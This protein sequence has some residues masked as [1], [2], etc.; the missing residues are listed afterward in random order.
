M[1]TERLHNLLQI[2]NN[3][4]SNLSIIS[5]AQ[6]FVNTFTKNIQQPTP[7]Q[8][9]TFNTAKEELKNALSECDSN[10]FVPSQHKMLQKINGDKCLGVGLLTE[11]EIIMNNNILTPGDAVKKVS[12]HFTKVN[13]FSAAIQSA[14]KS[15]ETLEIGFEYTKENEYE[16]GFL[17]PCK[18]FNND[19]EGLQKEVNLINRHMK[20]ICELVG[21]EITS[22]QIRS[23]ST[24]SLEVFLNALPEV[25][26]CIGECI[27]AIAILYLVIL[28]LRKHRTELKEEKVPKK[29][30]DPL[31]KHEKTRVE[32]EIKKLTNE[33]FKKYYKEKTKNR[34]N[35]LKIHLRQAIEF[36]ANRID[37]GVDIEV[38]PPEL[39]SNEEDT[40]GNEVKKPNKKETEIIKTLQSQGKALLKITTRSEEIV[41][42]LPEPEVEDFEKNKKTQ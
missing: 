15:F 9:Q 22:P 12:E 42:A 4:F 7:E 8:S 13:E 38:T 29:D 19:L 33:I 20:A 21:H 31:E 23:V 17:L 32:E 1:K 27:E 2:I 24:G 10:N 40:E 39:L 16:V 25:A 41:L 35:E 36:F 28:K 34:E 30:L 6:N 18:L 5:L 11:F 14:L 3:D 37:K 26:Q